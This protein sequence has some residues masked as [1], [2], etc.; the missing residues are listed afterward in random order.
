MVK[1]GSSN[2]SSTLELNQTPLAESNYSGQSLRAC[3]VTTPEH[4]LHSQSLAVIPEDSHEELLTLTEKEK[5]KFATAFGKMFI[6]VVS[7][8]SREL[9]VEDLKFYLSVLAHPGTKKPYIAPESY[10]HCSTTKHVL[11][12][13]FPQYIHAFHLD[14]LKA[15]IDLFGNAS[16]K[17][18][19][20]QY[21]S[22]LS[23]S[24]PM[25]ELGN[26]LTEDQIKACR[27]V[28]RIQIIVDKDPNSFALQDVE[29]IKSSIERATGVSRAMIVLVKSQPGSV[30]LHTCKYSGALH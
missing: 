18:L 14:L 28:T 27:G 12:S 21:E 15:I 19:L 20:S 9:D 3:E 22:T 4:E 24:M 16:S 5:F 26:P 17:D 8:L 1:D 13:L 25:S 10:E 7:Y 30:I 29:E 23:Y 2:G 6:K 11:Q